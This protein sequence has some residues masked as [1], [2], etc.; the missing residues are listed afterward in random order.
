M[1]YYSVRQF[2]NM[3]GV[4]YSS[5]RYFERIGLLKPR[6]D[7]QNNYRA[8][9]PQ[10]AFLVNRFKFYR[11]LGFEV[12]EAMSFIE[13]EDET[14]F[15]EKIGEQEENIKKQMLMLQHQLNTL[16]SIR[17]NMKYIE[18]E[19]LYERVYLKNRLF[20]PASHG[21][22]F[23]VSTYECFSKWVELLPI[24]TYC[25]IINKEE[26]INANKTNEKSLVMDYGI[27]INE[28]DAHLL[29]GEDR[30]KVK[31][32]KGGPCLLFYSDQFNHGLSGMSHIERVK[33][34]MENNGLEI[35]GDIFLEGA[36]VTLNQFGRGNMVYIPI[37]EK[38]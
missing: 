20:L 31:Y 34:Y 4:P 14:Y 6:Q 24:T 9:T 25:K 19:D 16:T 3:V 2:C 15:I 21:N 18:N 29:K 27:A 35:D 1:Q 13:N 26:F 28:E 23:S 38:C 33:L 8:Y 32:L 17:K 5:L 22:Q 7:E 10:D 36:R 37:K 30:G 11:S 12:K